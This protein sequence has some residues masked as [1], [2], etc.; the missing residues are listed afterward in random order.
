MQV[1][2]RI[3]SLRKGSMLGTLM[4]NNTNLALAL[5]SEGLAK[6]HSSC[7]DRALI[8]AQKIAVE[9]KKGVCTVLI[10]INDYY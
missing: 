1:V 9:A 5:V 10:K 3:E 7:S 2:I 4:I 6:V 8:Q